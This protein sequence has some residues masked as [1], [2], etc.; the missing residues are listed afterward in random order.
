MAPPSP[1]PL[2]SAA[3]DAAA[4]D[5]A[6]AE[7]V[8]F[9]RDLIRIPSINPPDPPGP[10]M[11]AAIFIADRLRAEGLAPEVI[12]SAPGRGNVTVRLRGDGHGP[13]ATRCCCSATTTSSRRAAR[14]AGPTIPSRP[15]SRTATSGAA[16]PWT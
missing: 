1:G 12:E 15:T 16:A 10:E 11:D 2:P 8:A 9:L 7:L 6:H 4:W 5:A 13:A 3:L 14:T